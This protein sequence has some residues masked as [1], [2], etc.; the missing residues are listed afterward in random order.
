MSVD[1]IKDKGLEI[2]PRRSSRHPAQHLTDT[3]FADDNIALISSALANAQS[4]LTSLE[5]AANCVGLYLNE[6][7][8]EYMNCCQVVDPTFKMTTLN[9]TELKCVQ[10]YKYLGSFVSDSEKDF[11][12]RKGMAWTVCNE[13]HKV[14]TSSLDDKIKVNT[15]KTIIE[16]I[17]LCGSEPWT[18]SARQQKRLDGMYTRLLMRV[19]NL[20]WKRHQNLQ[21]IYGDLPRVS[22]IVKARRV[23]FAGHCFRAA[24]EV[25]SPL[26]LWKPKPIG[27]KSWKL[28]Y[29]DVIARDSG[30]GLEDLGVAMQ[31]RDFWRD[32]VSSIS[33]AVER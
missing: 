30:I 33:T 18:L 6:T 7:K 21:Q 3:D 28:T 5:K 26:I 27:R 19:I 2:Q 22:Q 4:L 12:T 32:I 29:P 17:L 13:L 31:D 16:P 10:D 1:Q 24:N 25:I 23:Q 11:K 9:N 14:W 8:T 15:F 20:S